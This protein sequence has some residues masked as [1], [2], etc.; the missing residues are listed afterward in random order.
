MHE[1]LLTDA[2]LL[3]GLG[4]LDEADRVLSEMLGQ[5]TAAGDQ[6]L[7][8]RAL[9]GLGAVASERGL[10]AQALHLYEQAIERGGRPDPAER[11]SL[12][13]HTARLRSFSGDAGG[14]VTLIEEC[15]ARVSSGPDADPAVIA[16]YSIT[17][18]YAYADAGQYGRANSVLAGVLRDG[19][20]DL[21]LQ[22]RRRLYYALTRL[23]MNIGR[24]EQAIEYSEKNLETAIALD[25]QDVFL[26]YLQCAH[27]RLDANHTER[28]GDYLAEARRR[29]PDPLGS[30]D[31]GFLLVEEAR[32]SLQ[33]GDH[34]TALSRAS[35]AVELLADDPSGPGQSGLAHLV[36]ARVHDDRGDADAAD[37]GYRLAI[38]SL[39]RQTGW[40]TDLAKAYRRYG[41]F[42]RRRGQLDEAM[43]M[44]ELASDTAV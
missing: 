21:D 42:L 28:A 33:Q 6:E 41:K 13:T 29:A 24:S 3:I 39:E 7:A 9:E 35:A 26:V 14:A 8:G 40:P 43:R 10:E 32:F 2:T 37:R 30:V 31:A 15:L 20:E 11:E 19:G 27:V 23:N 22:V 18:S 1:S 36:I 38:D 34:D 17:L 44:L 12:Y 5:A 25:S 4:R 16:H